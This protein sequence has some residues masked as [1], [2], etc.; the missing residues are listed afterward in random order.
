MLPGFRLA[1]ISVLLAASVLI[2][3][4]GAAA[5][6]RVTREEFAFA[7][8]LRTLQTPRSPFVAEAPP[9]PPTLALL[10]VD[11]PIVAS[12]TESAPEPDAETT[13]AEAPSTPDTTLAADPANAPPSPAPTTIASI[14]A[15]EQPSAT[16]APVSV[17]KPHRRLR[18]RAHRRAAVIHRRRIVI[19][20][21]VR[22]PPPP[23]P[24]TSWFPLFLPETNPVQTT[25]TA[26][27][28][29]RT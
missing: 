26:T 28:T 27:T 15:Q 24:E 20:R 16:L 12:D 9:P 6:L 5:L 17:V 13:T 11:P 22:P 18:A 2:F 23:P 7:Q 1:M 10:R 3:G 21:Y 29:P 14:D 19:R 25:T 4:L 8:A